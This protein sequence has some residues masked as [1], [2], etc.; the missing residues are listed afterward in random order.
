MPAGA[1]SCA[2]RCRSLFQPFRRSRSLP[3]GGSR[4]SWRVGGTRSCSL[5][6]VIIRVFDPPWAGTSA[7]RVRVG[8]VHSEPWTWID[9]ELPVNDAAVAGVDGDARGT[10]G[11]VF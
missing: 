9:V 6:V 5:F 2:R 3:P 4:Q 10:G 1:R 11:V 8:A 7:G